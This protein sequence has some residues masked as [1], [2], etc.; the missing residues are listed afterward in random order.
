MCFDYKISPLND[1]ESLELSIS[2]FGS[3][4]NEFSLDYSSKNYREKL[5]NLKFYIQ[6]KF[7]Q[8]ES[9]SIEDYDYLWLK[10]NKLRKRFNQNCLKRPPNFV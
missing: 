10:Y 8:F 7:D 5:I 3:W 9:D 2:I 4:L 1:Y 6:N